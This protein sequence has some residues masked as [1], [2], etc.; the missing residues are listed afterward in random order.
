M[1]DAIRKPT[2]EVIHV[3]AVEGHKFLI[4]DGGMFLW[5]DKVNY[6]P[7]SGQAPEVKAAPK[8]DNAKNTATLFKALELDF[9]LADLLS[10]MC[11]GE[12]EMFVG[13]YF[14][15]R[16]K[17]GKEVDFV[18]TDKDGQSYRFESRDCLG[19]YDPMTKIDRFFNAV[20]AELPDPLTDRIM[21]IIRQYKSADGELM[22]RKCKLFL[23]SASEIFPADECYGDQGVYEQ[24]EWYKDVHNRIRAYEKGGA[25]DWYWTQ[26]PRSGNT[27]HWCTVYNYGGADYDL[28]SSTTIAAPVCFRIPRI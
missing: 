10:Q 22:E 11:S 3:Y 2:G 9:S 13:D 12:L 16:L 6:A 27:T 23:P 25:A 19:R 8:K 7:V 26:S 5:D 28:A 14:T 4:T 20:W 17:N 15:T 24:L 18:C 21:E 1:F